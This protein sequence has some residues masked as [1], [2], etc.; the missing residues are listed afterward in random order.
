M[1]DIMQVQYDTA[2]HPRQREF[3]QGECSLDCIRPTDVIQHR[4]YTSASGTLHMVSTAQDPPYMCLPSLSCWARYIAAPK[5]TEETTVERYLKRRSAYSEYIFPFSLGIP[6]FKGIPWPG[7]S[8]WRCKVPDMDQY[9]HD[10]NGRG[11]RNSVPALSPVRQ[12]RGVRKVD[13]IMA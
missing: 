12:H 4:C 5:S 3:L 7:A 9:R 6:E 11:V 1:A 2:F 13:T 8:T 10:I